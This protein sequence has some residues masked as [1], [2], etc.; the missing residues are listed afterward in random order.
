MQKARK[1]KSGFKFEGQTVYPLN[2]FSEG[3]LRKAVGLVFSELMTRTNNVKFEV[4]KIT[5][6]H[7]G[8]HLSISVK[9]DVDLEGYL[10]DHVIQAYRAVIATANNNILELAEK[11]LI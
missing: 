5:L 10:K 3:F 2:R 1:N 7:H 4:E 8:D 6:K 11:G 9:S